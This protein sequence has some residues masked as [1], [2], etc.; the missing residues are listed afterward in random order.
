MFHFRGRFVYRTHPMP[1]ASEI[2]QAAK[3][4]R[5]GRLVA[6]P[7]ETVYGL[8]A[9]ATS[10]AAVA[11][12]Y[13]VKARPSFNPLICHV[14]AQAH[15]FALGDFSRRAQDVAERFWPGP[16]TIV[17][18]RRSGCPVSMLASAGLASIGLRVPRHDMALALL[19]E[20]GGPVAAP[21]ANPSGRLSP[22][23]AQHVRYSLGDKVDVVL[24]GGPSPIGVESTVLGFLGDVP[25]L[26]RPGG[27]PRE[28]L[29]AFLGMRLE[30]E[31]N[32]ARPHAPGQLE[33]HYAPRARL[34]L[35]AAA[36]QDGE[37]FLGFGACDSG[38]RNLS[39]SGDTTEAAAN[40]FR[41]LHELDAEG[42]PVIAVA[43]IPMDGLGAAINDRL[44]RAAA[45]RAS[46]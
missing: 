10:D 5:E 37:A 4:L 35:N 39:P 21:S 33:S 11:A 31:A 2:S 14:A 18:P 3:A 27:I 40:L 17:V 25:R 22:T 8:G 29:E 6:F 46:A 36:P 45:P 38:A 15:A 44:A 12:L 41:M 24:D 34:R 23:T 7:T 13:A 16:L 20:F 42:S 43:P 26:L 19:R 9:D 1:S 30:A 28:Q 32:A